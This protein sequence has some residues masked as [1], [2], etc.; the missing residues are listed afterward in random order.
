MLKLMFTSALA[1]ACVLGLG[2]GI[3]A[4]DE[5]KCL[6]V[7]GPEWTAEGQSVDPARIITTGDVLRIT[8]IYQKL[9]EMDDNYQPQPVLAESWDSNQ[10]GTSWTFHLRKGVKFQDGRDFTAKD[11]VWSFQRLFDPKLDTGAKSILSMIDPS[12]IVAVDDSTVQFTLKAANAIFPAVLT[13]KYAAI[14]PNGSTQD[15]LQKHPVGTGPFMVDNFTPGPKFVA[16]RN[17]YYWGKGEPGADCIEF[18]GISET[19]SRVSALTSGQ[20]DLLVQLEPSAAATL[21]KSSGVKVLMAPGGMYLDFAMWV[22]TPP[23]NDERVRTAMKLVVDRNAFVNTV[24]LGIG[25]PGNDNPVSPL[26]PDAYQHAAIP[27]DIEKAKQLLADAGYPNGLKVDLYTSDSL[28]VMIP[29][30]QV[31]K[32]MAA[33]AGIDVNVIVSPADSYWTEI[34]LK[35]PFI[36][37]YWG[38]RPP[39]EALGI[40]YLSDSANNETHWKRPAYDALLNKANGT[41]DPDAR[42]ALYQQ[43]EKMLAEQGGVI[44][45]AFAT[46]TAAIRDGCSGFTPN[47]NAANFDFSTLTCK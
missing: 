13:T 27:Q 17:P 12:K 29:A 16:K 44:V 4:A 8:S 14:V 24:M 31:Y 6:R 20:A 33:K 18:S 19:V 46:T 41:I 26:S 3:A 40:A 38:D 5:A 45:P 22:D 32:Q 21:D 9:A 47:N 1:A 7:V 11:V 28:A 39:S 43:T 36:T 25:T 35:R 30:A 2:A 10:D 15:Q 37:S 23:F 42:R 34:F